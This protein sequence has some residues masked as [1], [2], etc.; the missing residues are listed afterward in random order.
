MGYGYFGKSLTTIN[1]GEVDFS[2]TLVYFYGVIDGRNVSKPVT[3]VTDLPLL[4]GLFVS[5]KILLS[6]LLSDYIFSIGI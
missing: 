3:T 2:L 1:L 5:S 4:V 6:T